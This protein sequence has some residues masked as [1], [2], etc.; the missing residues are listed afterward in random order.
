MIDGFVTAYKDNSGL[1]RI[2]F[3]PGYDDHGRIIYKIDIMLIDYKFVKYEDKAVEYILLNPDVS[4]IK[5]ALTNNK[6]KER[7]EYI[8]KTNKL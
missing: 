8:I 6:T 5:Y 3:Y 7:T 2:Y 4:E 1:V